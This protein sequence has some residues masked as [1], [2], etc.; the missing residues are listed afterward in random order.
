MKPRRSFARR[1]P[2]AG[3]MLLEALIAILI[4]SLGVLAL[5]GLQTVS[6]RQSSVAKYRA[7]ALMYANEIIGQMWVDN[8]T[9]ANL[10]ASYATGGAAY[11]AWFARLQSNNSLPGA[12]ANPPTITTVVA[13]AAA[14]PSTLVTVQVRWK[15]PNEPP[16]DPAHSVTVV[17][18]IK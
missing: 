13:G 18:Q 15:A 11:N 12:A 2:Q 10:S 14:D 5:V 9:F 8:R 7:D 6:I 16:A 3:V 17:A 1:A 4:F